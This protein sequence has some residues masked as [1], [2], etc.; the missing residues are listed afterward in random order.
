MMRITTTVAH[1]Q[2]ES[3]IWQKST[4]I[5]YE[6]SRAVDRQ[7]RQNPQTLCNRFGLK[8]TWT[9]PNISVTLISL[10]TNSY[11]G[12]SRYSQFLRSTI[13]Q[14]HIFIKEKR[15]GFVSTFQNRLNKTSKLS[16]RPFKVQFECLSQ[17][18]EWRHTQVMTTHPLHVQD[19]SFWPKAT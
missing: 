8:T 6:Q 18:T 11:S 17:N 2:K 16:K 19:N 4:R 14:I 9:P 12:G 10:S 1:P 7:R 3:A 5:P 15:L 13:T